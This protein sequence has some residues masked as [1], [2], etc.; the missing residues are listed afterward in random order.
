MKFVCNQLHRRYNLKLKILF[1]PV[2]EVAVSNTER[3]IRKPDE[4]FLRFST[5]APGKP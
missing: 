3:D 5:V 2:L 1:N 4:G